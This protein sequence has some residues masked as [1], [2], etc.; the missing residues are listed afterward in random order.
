MNED[1]VGEHIEITEHFLT[2]EQGVLP[3]LETN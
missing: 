3:C 2:S 1:T